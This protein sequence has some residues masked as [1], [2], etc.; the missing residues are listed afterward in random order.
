MIKNLSLAV[1]SVELVS[2]M[3]LSQPEEKKEGYKAEE[4]RQTKGVLAV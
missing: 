3:V 1:L 2:K 4:A